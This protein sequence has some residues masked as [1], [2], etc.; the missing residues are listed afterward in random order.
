MKEAADDLYVAELEQTQAAF[1]AEQRLKASA[2]PM[3]RCNAD[4][5]F[6]SALTYPQLTVKVGSATDGRATAQRTSAL[7]RTGPQLTVKA[8]M[9]S[10]ASETLGHVSLINTALHRTNFMALLRLK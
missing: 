3:G 7:E 2:D 9:G 5:G 6:A 10:L 8:N 4:V 1:E